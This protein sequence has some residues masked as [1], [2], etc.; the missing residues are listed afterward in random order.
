MSLISLVLK[1]HTAILVM[2]VIF[3][4]HTQSKKQKN[5]KFKSVLCALDSSRPA[6]GTKQV[7]R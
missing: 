6:K 5:E 7:R 1:G 2:E 4:R 3:F